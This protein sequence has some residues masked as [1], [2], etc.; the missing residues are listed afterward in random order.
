MKGGGG[1]LSVPAFQSDGTGW[2]VGGFPEPCS[3]LLILQR[4]T[5]G[6]LLEGTLLHA[7]RE[8]NQGAWAF[9]LQPT[10]N[11]VSLGKTP[12]FSVP[13]FF[14]LYKMKTLHMKT[15]RPLSD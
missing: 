8:G 14:F 10:I 11:F 6:H 3:A 1:L 4:A 13:L 15:T 7:F 5:T 9:I 12:K 2:W